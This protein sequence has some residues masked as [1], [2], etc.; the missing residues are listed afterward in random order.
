MSCMC[1]E[2]RTWQ[3]PTILRYWFQSC[4]RCG[5][6]RN[7]GDGLR[8]SVYDADLNPQQW[9]WKGSRVASLQTWMPG[10]QHPQPATNQKPFLISTHTQNLQ[11]SCLCTNLLQICPF[12]MKFSLDA[13]GPYFLLVDVASF[14]I[15]I[16]V[17]WG[18]MYILVCVWHHTCMCETHVCVCEFSKHERL[19]IS[20]MIKGS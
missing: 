19:S 14:L 11:S 12:W 3:V 16:S 5:C 18:T 17:L 13:D 10:S 4:Q 7:S 8:F 2:I 20:T 15:V 6:L 1:T 9:W